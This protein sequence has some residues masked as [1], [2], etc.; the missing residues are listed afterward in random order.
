MTYDNT[1]RT[2]LDKPHGEALIEV[3]DLLRARDNYKAEI[4]T[5]RAERAKL[6]QMLHELNRRAQDFHDQLQDARNDVSHLKGERATLEQKLQ[7]RNAEV[8]TLKKQIEGLKA[9]LDGW[10]KQLQKERD[11]FESWKQRATEIAHRYADEHGLCEAFDECMKEI[12]LPPRTKDYWVDVE[13]CTK[14][15]VR[16]D[17]VCSEDDAIEQATIDLVREELRANLEAY[18]DQHAIE[19]KEAYEV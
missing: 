6:D 4:Q 2:I 1:A 15:T 9:D 8:E 7:E 12:G 17:G 18:V 11:E 16:V 3:T 19:D 14:V 10:R 13:I 5:L